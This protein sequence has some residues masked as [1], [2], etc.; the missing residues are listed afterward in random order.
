MI[1]TRSR[2]GLRLCQGDQTDGHSMQSQGAT[3]KRY[4]IT[5]A[6]KMIKTILD[7]KLF[8]LQVVQKSVRTIMEN[9]GWVAS[10]KT[11]DRRRSLVIE[12]V[13]IMPPNTGDLRH[14]PRRRSC[15]NR[16]NKRQRSRSPGSCTAN[17]GTIA[18]DHNG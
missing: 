16:P 17:S 8:N 2:R 14:F 18:S 6:T 4:G 15:R 5:L 11:L 12:Q 7:G 3:V 1:R 10:R 13:A 9:L